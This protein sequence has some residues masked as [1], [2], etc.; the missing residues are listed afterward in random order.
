M[1]IATLYFDGTITMTTEISFGRNKSDK[2]VLM[3]SARNAF[4]KV[5]YAAHL[6]DLKQFVCKM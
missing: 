1:T 2:F 5:F 3:K 6:M 4:E